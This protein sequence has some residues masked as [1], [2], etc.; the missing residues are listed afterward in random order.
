[1]KVYISP[2]KDHKKSVTGRT[3]EPQFKSARIESSSQPSSPSTPFNHKFFGKTR[4]TTSRGAIHSMPL[5]NHHPSTSSENLLI[6]SKTIEENQ[7]WLI[8]NDDN[9][10]QPI[11]E[12]YRTT[13]YQNIETLLAN[14]DLFTIDER[15]GARIPGSHKV[16][17]IW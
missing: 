4:N 9:N 8:N 11:A 12:E 1:M 6:K 7:I 5:V 13:K 17:R 2:E 16:S 15:N 3:F 10:F 14:T